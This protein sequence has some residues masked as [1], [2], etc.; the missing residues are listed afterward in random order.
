MW[1]ESLSSRRRLTA[2]WIRIF[3]SAEP[4]TT[5]SYCKRWT[6]NSGL[7]ATL[8]GPLRRVLE[9]Q[10]LKSTSNFQTSSQI[11]GFAFHV[12]IH[13]FKFHL[14]TSL[15]IIRS[16]VFQ[17]AECIF[18]EETG[19]GR[20]AARLSCCS[21]VEIVGSSRGEVAAYAGLQVL[22]NIR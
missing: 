18:R 3:R 10:V 11:L 8:V 6:L 19:G 16:P 5:A 14:E 21:V 1:Q 4:T 12:R 22:Q 7:Q 2:S 17:K 20:S 15:S 13:T 9:N